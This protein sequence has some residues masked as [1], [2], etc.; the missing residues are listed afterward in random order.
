MIAISAI[1]HPKLGRALDTT[2]GSDGH[3]SPQPSASSPMVVH[4]CTPASEGEGSCSP[5]GAVY[6]YETEDESDDETASLV[7]LGAVTYV[8]TVVRR[9]AEHYVVTLRPYVPLVGS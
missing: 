8:L 7:L 2:G 3:R 5:V 1:R 9:S 6:A 4:G